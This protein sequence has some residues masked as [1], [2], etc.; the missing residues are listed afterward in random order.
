[1]GRLVRP[2]EF[3]LTRG[4]YPMASF[5]VVVDGEP[6]WDPDNKQSLAPSNFISCL[7]FGSEAKPMRTFAK[8]D[9]L[10]V[11]GELSQEDVE[12]EDGQVTSKTRVKA[13]LVWPVDLKEKQVTDP[14]EQTF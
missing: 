9:K 6:K 3:M 7:I 10:Y 14:P 8:G 2:P 4:G 13:H 12:T 11:L 5:T 1:M